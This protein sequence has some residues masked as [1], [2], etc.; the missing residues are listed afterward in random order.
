MLNTDHNI[1]GAF[2]PHWTMRNP[3][4]QSL[5]VGLKL[6]RALILMRPNPMRRAAREHLLDC[7]DGVRLQ[8]FYSPQPAGS[9]TRGLVVLL[10]GWEG[11]ADS[12]YMLSMGR[13]LYDVGYEVFRLNFRD[14]GDTQHLNTG[15]FHSNRILE[16]VG[17]LREIARRFPTRPLLLAG[18]SLGGNFAL[19]LAL[20]SPDAGIPLSR[21]VAVNP[22]IDPAR[23]LAA[24]D[25]GLFVY[26]HYF[27][28]K[29][30][31]SLRRKQACFPDRY[32]FEEW[33][34]LPSLGT[35]TDYLA[36]HYTEFSGA[37]E[38]F[39]GY[40]VAGDRLRELRIPATVITAQ[41]DPII[42]ISDYYELVKPETLTLEIMR[43]GGHCGYF[44]GPALRSWIER[45]VLR[46]LT[47]S[48]TGHT[49][50][51]LVT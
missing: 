34:R 8:G 51:A 46:E 44:E 17:A 49:R 50:P 4:V 21:A 1:R 15:I 25:E 30:R 2:R 6:R 12:T 42:P 11:S 31:W 29:W 19:R 47:E 16:V 36:R 20:R 41:D 13:R 18:F 28:K 22:V 48:V 35:M 14:H 39:D 24:M 27:M 37:R 23:S 9:D 10:H 32:D 5:V 38:Y 45:R 40:S 26:R 7:G 3:H 43:Y 33:F